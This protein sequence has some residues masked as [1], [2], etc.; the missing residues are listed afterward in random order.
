MNSISRQ[1]FTYAVFE[2]DP[3]RDY[4]P[5]S[6][7]LC[8]EIKEKNCRYASPEQHLWGPRDNWKNPFYLNNT[9]IFASEIGY[10]GMPAPESV[11]KFI[12]AESV[13]ARSADDPN[14][15]THA[16]QP[17]SDRSGS[18]SYRIDLMN[19]QIRNTFGFIPESFEEY[20]EASQTVQAE[21][22][23]SFIEGFRRQKWQKTGLIWWNIID[24]WPQFSDAVVDYYYNKKL[25]FHYIKNVQ[26]PVMMMFDE[27]HSWNI[28][29][30]GVNDLDHPVEV[31]YQVRDFATG[32]VM[33]SGQTTL[34]EDSAMIVNSMKVCQGEQRILCIDFNYEDTCGK[35]HY[36]MAN[37]PV[38]WDLYSRFLKS[39][40][41]CR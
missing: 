35:N 27:P 2:N 15:L 40:D 22:L 30:Y 24:C 36:L 8:D 20:A 10:H 23:K 4:L 18:F 38:S 1:V 9:A 37:P 7:Y 11:K 3:A 13:N 32:E 16:S 14:W 6:P 5:S 33:M 28:R 19:D 21:A 25:A 34:A 12:P 31:T 39:P 41:C 17:F 26:K 29:L